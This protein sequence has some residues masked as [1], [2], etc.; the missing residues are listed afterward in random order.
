[1]RKRVVMPS[2]LCLAWFMAA[3]VAYGQ[4]A[5]KWRYAEASPLS[6]TEQTELE[7]LRR[8]SVVTH[9]AIGWKRI[10]ELFEPTIRESHRQFSAMQWKGKGQSINVPAS[11]MRVEGISL[12]RFATAQFPFEKQPLEYTYSLSPDHLAIAH[13][14]DDKDGFPAGSGLIVEARGDSGFI[15]AGYVYALDWEKYETQDALDPD[16]PVRSG[17]VKTFIY[18]DD[19]SQRNPGVGAIQLRAL[20]KTG[21]EGKFGGGSQRSVFPPTIGPGSQDHYILEFGRAVQ[22][23]RKKAE[24]ERKAGLKDEDNYEFLKVPLLITWGDKVINDTVL[25][26]MELD[27]HRRYFNLLESVLGE[28]H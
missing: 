21:F 13:F 9:K 14:T 24:A 2:I 1:M 7:V 3:S 4:A 16:Y 6:P 27:A 19:P 5:P 11:I 28:H 23:A 20:G 12:K 26:R 18:A 8:Y 22:I 25:D 15:S 17:L 10:L